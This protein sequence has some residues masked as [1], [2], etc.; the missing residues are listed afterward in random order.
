M[1][2][3]EP[4][5]PSFLQL[6]EELGVRV[7]AEL[8][9]LALTHRSFAYENGNIPNNER[10]EFLGDSVLGICVTDYLYKHFPDHPEGKLAKMRAS[11]VSSVSLAR[12]ARKL[13]IGQL[14]KLGH[15]ELTTGGRNKTSILADTTEA[16]IGAIYLTDVPSARVFVHHLFDPL[17]DR[18]DLSGAALDWKTSLQEVCAALGTESPE[19]DISE[20]GPDH[21]KRFVA[22]VVVADRRFE[23]AEGHN[24]KQAE[25]RA[26]AHAF[27]ILNQELQ[28]RTLSADA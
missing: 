18:A 5:S 17:V 25:Q 4:G 28:A 2:S 13:G 21:N 19:Y 14:V 11:V 27:R 16:L 1:N 7:D 15:G 24:K 23:P 6:I 22:V 26:A 8:L 12:V 3:S 20:S 10:L 9:D